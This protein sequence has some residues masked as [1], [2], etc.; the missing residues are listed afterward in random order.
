MGLGG[1]DKE[2]EEEWSRHGGGLPSHL[3]LLER[4]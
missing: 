3:A 1:K 4:A 2:Q